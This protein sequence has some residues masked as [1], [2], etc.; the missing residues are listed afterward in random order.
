M[1]LS[2]FPRF[3]KY[4]QKMLQKLFREKVGVMPIADAARKAGVDYSW[5][6]LVLDGHAPNSTTSREFALLTAEAFGVDRDR[7]ARC[8]QYPQEGKNFQEVPQLLS[9]FGIDEEMWNYF[10]R[11][12]KFSLIVARHIKELFAEKRAEEKR[13][14]VVPA[15]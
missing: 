2:G 11:D 1:R 9:K 14:A 6:S 12:P 15:P 8:F 5:L 3:S 13:H 7:V 10:I 4:Q